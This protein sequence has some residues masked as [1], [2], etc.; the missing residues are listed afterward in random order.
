[1]K[2]F[3][4]KI[5]VC[6]QQEH[7]EVIPYLVNLPKVHQIPKATTLEPW[8]SVQV[9]GLEPL[10]HIL[11]INVLQK[12]FMACL[13]EV[14]NVVLVSCSKEGKAVS[15]ELFGLKVAVNVVE[16]SPA[17]IKGHVGDVHGGERLL[18]EVVREHAA[19]DRGPSS[20]HSAVSRDAATIGGCD[21][22]VGEDTVREHSS[23]G[24]ESSG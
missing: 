12:A 9:R 24:G 3:S 2:D 22:N 11:G 20:K 19:E 17:G 23:K 1:M 7:I 5:A 14:S 4:Y 18:L 13:L 8:K 15:Q 6:I 10:E 21:G 16:E